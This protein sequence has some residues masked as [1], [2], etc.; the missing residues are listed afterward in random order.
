MNIFFKF[1]IFKNKEKNNHSDSNIRFFS[2]PIRA[3]LCN[4][5]HEKNSSLFNKSSLLALLCAFFFILFSNI[6]ISQPTVQW[7]KTFGGSR[8]ESMNSAFKT[9]DEGFLLC[10]STSSEKGFDVSE[11]SR[12]SSDY[13]VVRNAP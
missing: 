1:L 4:L 13:W 10:G 2:F 11:V 5:K 12:G 6:L 3:F 7:D 8:W 9:D